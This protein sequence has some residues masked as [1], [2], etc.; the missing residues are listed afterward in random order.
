MKFRHCP[1]TERD[2]VT[3]QSSSATVSSY[4]S[5]VLF[6]W[7]LNLSAIR[8]LLMTKTFSTCWVSFEPPTLRRLLRPYDCAW[9]DPPVEGSAARE[10][11]TG[12][13]VGRQGVT[14]AWNWTTSLVGN[15]NASKKACKIFPWLCT[16]VTGPMMEGSVGHPRESIS[17]I[18]AP[19]EPSMAIS[20][21]TKIS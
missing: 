2:E 8:I 13:H 3:S 4:S 5:R 16:C 15:L 19:S 18:S 6:S 21:R 9:N 1:D 17:T 10:Q 11:S 14:S 20:S 12:W 7:N